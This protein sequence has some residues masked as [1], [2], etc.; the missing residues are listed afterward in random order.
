MEYEVL[1]FQY[2]L[3]TALASLLKDEGI[4]LLNLFFDSVYA[5]AELA[6][7]ILHEI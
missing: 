1:C 2:G 4:D 5:G 7:T 3:V 6:P